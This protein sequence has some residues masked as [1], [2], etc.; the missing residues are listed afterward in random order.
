MRHKFLLAGM[1]T[2]RFL[3][4]GCSEGTYVAGSAELG[5]TASGIEIDDAKVRRARSR[6]LDVRSVDLLSGTASLPRADFVMLRHVVEHVPDFVQFTRIAASAVAEGGVLWIEC[7]NQAALAVLL[8]RNRIRQQRYLGA[9]YP[10]THIHA[11]ESKALRRLGDKIG[12]RLERIVTCAPSDCN[13]NPP[14]QVRLSPLKRAVHRGAALLGY[15]KDL[16]AVY[17]KNA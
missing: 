9:L 10:P 1:A 2:G 17:R 12:L 15:G 11:F 7:P 3:D 16:A 6:G 14:Y 5:W 13:W 4:I 8:K